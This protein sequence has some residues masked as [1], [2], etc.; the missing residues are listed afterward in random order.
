MC[1]IAGG[2][3]WG[4]QVRDEAALAA[5]RKMVERLAHR[6]PDGKGVWR[7][8]RTSDG[9]LVV[10][11]HTR[12]AI[13]DTSNAGAQPMCAADESACI[14]YNGE[15]YNFGK[16]RS[17]LERAGASFQ[18]RSDTEVILRGYDVWGVDVL[19][20][21]RGMFAFGL[22][23]AAE[24][25]LL[26]AR[27][28][29]GIKPLYYF[30]AD[31]FFLF[32]SE[33]RALV[34]TGLVPGRINPVA[35][36][37]YLGYQ[38]VPAP[39]TMIDGVRAL[40]PGQWIT[41]DARGRVASGEYWNMLTAACQSTDPSPSDARRQTADLLREAVSAHMVSDVPVG[42]FLSGGIDSSA[43]VALIRDAGHQ[44]RTFSVGFDDRA[45]DETTYAELV[46]RRFG[47]DHTHIALRGADLLD[48]LPGALAAMDQP[49]GDGVNTY[50]VSSAVAERG[51]KVALS[52]LGGDEI[53]GGYPSFGRLGRVSDVAR[54]WG[55]SPDRLRMLVG[56]AVRAVAGASVQ[57]AKAAALVESDGSVASM[58]PV[59]RQMF[60]SG[61]RR[62]LM[63]ARVLHGI[64]P[65][66]P[67]EQRL[68]RA[69]ER[70]PAASVFAQIS[71]A[72]A[73][74][75]MHDVLLRDTDQMAMAHALE[76][77]VPLLDHELVEHVMRLPDRIKGPNGAAAKRLLVE[78]LDGL[79][80]DEIV[81]R[82]KQGF[83]LPF[84][85]WMRGP[86]RAFCEE[87]LGDRGLGGC[88]LLE[89]VAVRRLWES[90]LAGAR[91]VSW[92]RLWTLVTLDVW[93]DRNNLQQ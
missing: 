46:A 25:R 3:F 34:A 68:A 88:N 47:A 44:P 15:T 8:G 27:D 6:G 37:H 60:S 16:L 61:Q 85:R 59:T 9:P 80:P 51:L 31:G 53:F 49:T 71:Y 70:A 29:L 77:R 45:F 76:V 83:T 48:R 7:A 82:P 39:L 56:G 84:D 30:A 10:L 52:G 89:P 12:L 28:R 57:G 65:D 38:S 14:T 18:S 2:V 5:V 21:L 11:G 1:G 62:A 67:Y 43:V 55:R 42:A 81:R 69:F 73:R 35:L 66:D 17:E 22:W 79:L 26:L 50:I 40:E 32:A 33:V 19:P 20:R 92:S 93:L 24:E 90:F 78:S 23:D 54:L 36:W 13:I 87:H 63:P 72:E 74:T 86:L 4:N 75:Y 64:D 58:F 91:D 41:V